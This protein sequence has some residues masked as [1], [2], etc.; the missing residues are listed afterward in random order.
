MR[1][2][3]QQIIATGYNPCTKGMHKTVS[4]SKRNT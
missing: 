2:N 3:A 4:P 1:K